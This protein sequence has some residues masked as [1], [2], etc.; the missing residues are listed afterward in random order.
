MTPPMS[1]TSTSSSARRR[2]ACRIPEVAEAASRGIPVILRGELLAELMR[3]KQGVAIAGAHGKTTTTVDDRSGAR[4]RGTGSD[5]RDRGPSRGS[6]AAARASA[7]ATCSSPRPTKAIARSCCLR[8]SIAVVTNI[9]REHLES[10]A[11]LRRPRAGVRALLGARAVLRR[12]RLL[13]RRRPDAAPPR[14][15]RSTRRRSPYGLDDA[16]A[17]SDGD[18]RRCSKGS[19]S[20]ATV[21]RRTAD[22]TRDRS[23]RSRSRC[24]AATTCSTRWRPWASACDLG[25][26]FPVDRRGAGRISRRRAPVRAQGRGERRHR[27]WTT[28]GT[29]RPKSRRCCGPRERPAPRRIVCVFQPH[30]YSRTA[31]LL[32]EFGP[33]LALA[34]EVV[35]TDIYPAGEDPMP[36]VTIEAL[37]DEV[38]RSRAAAACTSSRRWPTC[39]PPSR[40]WPRRATWC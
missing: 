23:A 28:T 24:P 32:H 12:G 21:M 26:P 11:Q 37:A 7:A 9:D 15:R 33:A 4:S 17:R 1:A 25:V 8:P 39:R 16:D 18:R 38:Q 3:E 5:G 31:H 40:A 2:C 22:G 6:S 36:G 13:H 34:D 19:E 20:R 10:Y 29:T 27:S 30:R 35:L 14:R